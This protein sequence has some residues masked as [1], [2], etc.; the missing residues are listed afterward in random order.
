MAHSASPAAADN[1]LI[2]ARTEFANAFGD[3]A[4]GKRNWQL[5]ALWTLALLT[6]STIAYVHLAESARVVPYVVTVDRVGQVVSVNEAQALG[7]PDPRLVAAQLAAFLRAVRGVLPASAPQLEADVMRRAYAFVDQSS[8]AAGT[9]NAYFA[10]P[11][12]DPRILGGRV[13]RTVD[14]TSVLPVPNS[15]AWKLRWSETENPIQIGGTT[16]A[17]AW[18]G[19]LTLRIR[20]ATTADAVQDNPLGLYVTTIVWTQIAEPTPTP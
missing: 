11:A 16:R 2:A 12:H 17:S 18:E 4:R 20:P 19:Y 10:D 13:T 6:I 15:P 9:L 7:A 14:V 1:R 8:P 5:V 3:L